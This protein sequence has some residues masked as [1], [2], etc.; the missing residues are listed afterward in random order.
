M[1]V[2]AQSTMDRTSRLNQHQQNQEGPRSKFDRK[3]WIQ[4]YVIKS[5]SDEYVQDAGIFHSGFGKATISQNMTTGNK[6]ARYSISKMLARYSSM[7]WIYS[8]CTQT[9]SSANFC[10]T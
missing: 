2:L 4:A 5:Y 9:M 3:R 8:F 7:F 1:M 6:L 10:D